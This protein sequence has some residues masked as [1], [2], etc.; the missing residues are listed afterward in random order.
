M[1]DAWITENYSAILNG[2]LCV[3]L[4]IL[5]VFFV[6]FSFS[7]PDDS[8]GMKEQK[9][10]PPPP[11]TVSD[12]VPTLNYFWAFMKSK[13]PKIPRD[14]KDPLCIV[15][16]YDESCTTCKALFSEWA[17]FDSI[18]PYALNGVCMPRYRLDLDENPDIRMM[19]AR[20]MLPIVGILENGDWKHFKPF[21]DSYDNKDRW[22]HGVRQ[23]LDARAA[24]VAKDAATE[25]VVPETTTVLPRQHEEPPPEL[26]PIP[27][28]TDDFPIELVHVG[29]NKARTETLSGE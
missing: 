8:D 18:F 25:S 22:V 4:L 16:L 2:V 23:F 27:E 1:I 17:D 12:A 11:Q 3:L 19:S 10:P 9:A 24:A 28:T 29:N 7:S 20:F 14:V 15:Y 5:I 6:C 13:T 26:F 21:P